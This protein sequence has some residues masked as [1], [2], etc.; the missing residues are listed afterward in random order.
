M[1]VPRQA[2]EPR[3]ILKPRLLAHIGDSQGR[4]NANGNTNRAK[5][6]MTE[7][8]ALATLFAFPRLEAQGSML[9]SIVNYQISIL[10]AALIRRRPEV[11]EAGR[12]RLQLDDCDPNTTTSNSSF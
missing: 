1:Y 11:I 5:G 3:E 12:H 9:L 10:K 7:R 4:K 2:S 8:A 6:S